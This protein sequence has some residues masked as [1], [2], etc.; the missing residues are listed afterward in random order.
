MS[1]RHPANFGP[2]P[3]PLRVTPRPPPTNPGPPYGH[4]QTTPI[5]AP[6]HLRAVSRLRAG[7]SVR[8]R[9]STPQP[10]CRARRGGLTVPGAGAARRP[11][12][13][14]AARRAG[15][16]RGCSPRLPA[17][18]RLPGSGRRR[19]MARLSHCSGAA[20]GGGRASPRAGAPNPGALRP[21]RP[22][23]R[24]RHTPAA[25]PRLLFCPSGSFQGQACG[26]LK[27]GDLVAENNPAAEGGLRAA[28]R[29]SR[30]RGF[31]GT[32]GG[33][34]SPALQSESSRTCV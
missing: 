25:P 5:S 3:E 21:P 31:L 23:A 14:A 12:R 22:G 18:G 7:T 6:V 26:L 34:R 15:G 1:L 4:L 27:S 19:P 8:C 20:A 30:A 17:G 32:V 2:P 9:P 33:D 11:G 28:A 16:G 24:A 10:P 29:R 13:V